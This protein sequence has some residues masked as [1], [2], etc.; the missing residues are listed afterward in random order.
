MNEE[1]FTKI[2]EQLGTNLSYIKAGQKSNYVFHRN[3]F[4]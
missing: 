1:S 2:A 3:E 4:Q